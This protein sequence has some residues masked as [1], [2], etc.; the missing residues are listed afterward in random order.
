[1]SS[2]LIAKQQ[3]FA[4]MLGDLLTWAPVHGFDVTVGEVERS[5]SE[6][7]ANAE[8]GSGVVHSLH[9]IRLA[10]D[11]HLYIDG[12]YQTDSKAYLALGQYWE[13]LGGSWGGR[14][15]RP[16]GNHFS[17]SYNGVR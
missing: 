10:V 4:R 14:F 2:I 11:L 16:D 1:M 8:A 15:A 17:L 3:Q 9:I 7:Q 12:I 5:A 13:A 6:A